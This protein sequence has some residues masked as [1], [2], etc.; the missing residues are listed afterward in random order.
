VSSGSLALT[1]ATA[2]GRSSW[3][4]VY[5]LYFDAKVSITDGRRVPRQS[6]VWWPQATQIA[7]ACRSLGLPSVLEVSYDA[8]KM[9]WS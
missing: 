8:C 7:Q 5:P 6:S 3:N 1:E 9:A 4:C 2:H